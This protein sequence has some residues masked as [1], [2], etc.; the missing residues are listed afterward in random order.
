MERP[1]EAL[2]LTGDENIIDINLTVLWVID[3]KHVQDYLFNIR[4]PEQTVKSVAE[5]A[6]REVVG[7]TPIA[8]VLAEG[9]GKV[10]TD[11]QALIQSVLDSYGAGILIQQVQLQ[12]AD[13]PAEVID[14]FR[15]V[16]RALTDRD[17]AKNEAEAYH[18]DAVPRA[19]GDAEQI[20]QA[21][22]AYKLQVVA[23]ASGDTQRFLSVLNAYRA[24]KDVTAERLYIDTMEQVL[25]KANKVLIDKSAGGVLPY[26]PL[27]GLPASRPQPAP[28]S[29]SSPPAA[30][31][32]QQGRS[33][34]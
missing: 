26:L 30:P 1:E 34:R 7:R 10:E 25:K 23:Q 19:R 12:K 33:G 4:S 11:T 17:R 6:V 18:N 16:Q 28:D 8:S 20:V 3:A 9:R 32:A 29:A 22:E 15:D 13:P 27:P 14:S 21:A 5:A 31:A 24:A 2:M